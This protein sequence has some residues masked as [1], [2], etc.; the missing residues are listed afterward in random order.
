MADGISFYEFHFVKLLQILSL[1]LLFH[2]CK[3]LNLFL[4]SQI[5]Q[6]T[7]TP[8]GFT[9]L[10]LLFRYVEPWLHVCGNGED[11]SLSIILGICNLPLL[12][13]NVYGSVFGC[14]FFLA[15][16]CLFYSYFGVKYYI[17]YLFLM[18]IINVDISEGAILLWSWQPWS[19]CQN[20]Q[21]NDNSGF[22]ELI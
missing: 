1:Q 9:G 11:C 12:L 7:R 20:C 2:H 3:G 22:F 8:C 17:L 21:G 4:A 6:G 16:S 18:V 10:W 13:S 14:D 19:A 15:Y 5:L